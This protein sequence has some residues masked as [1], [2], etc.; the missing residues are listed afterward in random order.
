LERFKRL[1]PYLLLGPISGLLVA[2]VVFNVKA[3]R[4]LLAAM[5]A[6]LLIQY[7]VLLPYATAALG[8]RLL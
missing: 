7:V 6:T 4:P 3:G 2:G 8:I 1:A 5:Y